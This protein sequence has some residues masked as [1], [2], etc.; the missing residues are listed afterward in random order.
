M[1]FSF[2]GHVIF[3]LF[4]NAFQYSA[5]TFLHAY[6][7]LPTETLEFRYIAAQRVRPLRFFGETR[8]SGLVPLEFGK[9][10]RYLLKSRI[11]SKADIDAASVAHM[12][13]RSAK[14][15]N[16]VIDINKITTL[17]ARTPHRKRIFA[18]RCAR[19][20]RRNRV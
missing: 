8:N 4:F 5:K 9:D 14:C 18:P 7:R 15:R 6:A 2:F 13:D 17:I 1:Q 16:K 12:S 20:D 11:I 19:R 3:L 10:G